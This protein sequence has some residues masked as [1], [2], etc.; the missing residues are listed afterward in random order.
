M[1][2]L[3]RE[4]A[5]GRDGC[6]WAVGWLNNQMGTLTNL[7]WFATEDEARVS[8]SRLTFPE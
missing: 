3:I 5:P 2:V 4:V 1:W 7:S 6:P 8:H